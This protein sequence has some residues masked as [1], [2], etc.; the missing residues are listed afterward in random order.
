MT[1]TGQDDADEFQNG[2]VVVH[3]QDSGHGRIITA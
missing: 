1:G 2:G 3:H